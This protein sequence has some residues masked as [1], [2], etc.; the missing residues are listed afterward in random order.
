MVPFDRF[1]NNEVWL[2]E[3]IEVSADDDS[4]LLPRKVNQGSLDSVGKRRF[5]A[6]TL[7][8]LAGR[9]TTH[10][11]GAEL[12]RRVVLRNGVLRQMWTSIKHFGVWK[13]S[14][15][16]LLLPSS[17]ERD[18]RAKFERAMQW[19]KASAGGEPPDVEVV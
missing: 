18:L 2:A 14:S 15:R 19:H 11:R 13:D 10:I 17:V 8:H 6:M 5:R 12:L 16:T 1:V 9:A 7:S 3:V 4:C